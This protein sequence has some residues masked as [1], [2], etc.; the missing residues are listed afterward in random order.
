MNYDNLETFMSMA[1][2]NDQSYGAQIATEIITILS[3]TTVSDMERMLLLNIALNCNTRFTT[4]DMTNIKQ[5]DPTISKKII[6][7]FNCNWLASQNIDSI[8]S[9]L[10]NFFPIV[11]ND[12]DTLS[13]FLNKLS[14]IPVNETV[15]YNLV[16][17]IHLKDCLSSIIDIPHNEIKRN[18]E[19]LTILEH[20][21]KAAKKQHKIEFLVILNFLKKHDELSSRRATL[22]LE[23]LSIETDS[24]PKETNNAKDKL[25]EQN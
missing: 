15:G 22:E 20:C 7:L 6:N 24:T 1:M 21:S 19:I 10:M 23:L 3:E 8:A 18:N 12:A 17:S 13:A 2:S 4:K 9:Y 14:Q 25:E 16:D 5:I 11:T